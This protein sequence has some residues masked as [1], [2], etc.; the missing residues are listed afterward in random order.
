MH[1]FGALN[2][3]YRGGHLRGEALLVMVAQT[4]KEV[5]PLALECLV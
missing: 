4:Q 2:V 1:R 5:G 3:R